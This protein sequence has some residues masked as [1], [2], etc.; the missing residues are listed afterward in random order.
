[1]YDLEPAFNMVGSQDS[2]RMARVLSLAVNREEST[3][4]YER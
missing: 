2:G 1:M 4:L 3:L